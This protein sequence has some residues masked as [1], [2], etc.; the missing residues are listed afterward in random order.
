[1]LRAG[2]AVFQNRWDLRRYKGKDIRRDNARWTHWHNST[3]LR[4]GSSYQLPCFFGSKR[5]GVGLGFACGV[6]SFFQP[7]D[8]GS[9]G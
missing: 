7:A 2:S 4:L 5:S 6:V 8:L 3:T 9:E 1:M